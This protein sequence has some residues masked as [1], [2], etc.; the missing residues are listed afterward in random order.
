M[1]P[2]EALRCAGFGSH[3][4]TYELQWC[5]KILP[6]KTNKQNYFLIR[7]MKDSNTCFIGLFRGLHGTMSGE[8]RSLCL[9]LAESQQTPLWSEIR[10]NW[11]RQWTCGMR[12]SLLE[13]LRG[14]EEWAKSSDLQNS[15]EPHGNRLMSPSW[16]M[17]Q[18]LSPTNQVLCST[19]RG[20]GKAG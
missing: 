1:L 4:A 18:W 10:W 13:G 14:Q 16:E 20:K 12:D 15:I 9:N 7:K 8:C 6:Q 2:L 17:D 3:T 5:M 11:E 19:S